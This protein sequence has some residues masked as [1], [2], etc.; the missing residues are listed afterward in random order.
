[1]G[2]K[3][4]ID[5]DIAIRIYPDNDYV[6]SVN[7]MGQ[8]E[9]MKTIQSHETIVHGI[10]LPDYFQGCGTSFT[11]YTDVATGIGETA[12]EAFEDA[13]ESLSQ[14]DWDTSSLR[15]EQGKG[16]P[17]TVAGY[18]KQQGIKQDEDCSDSSYWH[19]S[20]RVK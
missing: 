1:M 15:L 19:V 10:M 11:S 7:V 6:D 8:S 2:V 13:C 12:A 16:R 5:T 18:L 9:G 4:C 20:I 14:N 17:L 3:G